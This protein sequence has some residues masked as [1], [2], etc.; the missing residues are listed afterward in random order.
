MTCAVLFDMDGVISDTASIHTKAWKAVFDQVLSNIDPSAPPFNETEDYLRYVDGKSRPAGIRDFLSSRNLQL[1]TGEVTDSN[2]NTIC[3]IGNDKNQI[4]RKFLET[5]GVKLFEDALIA[6]NTLKQNNA[7]L[8][9]ASSSKNASLVLER[10]GLTEYFSSILDGE[11]A[12]ENGIKSK[13]DPE[14]YTFAA[15]LLGKLPE[16]CIVIEDAIS[17][18]I[19][20]RDAGA[21]LIIGIDRKGD[22]ETLRTNGAGIVV[23]SLNELDFSQSKNI[24]RDILHF[25]GGR[26]VQ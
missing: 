20:A 16:E 23:S 21:G 9:L 25:Q 24:F 3:G 17:G 2:V 5:E 14:F 26:K 4:F 11:V 22:G 19:S 8:G 13:P 10:T 12:E 1:P 15:R 18:V 7:L 6:L